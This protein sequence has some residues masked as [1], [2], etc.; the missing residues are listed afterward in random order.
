V[1]PSMRIFRRQ[2]PPEESCVCYS[3]YLLQVET[4]AGR[5]ICS[6][7]QRFIARK[8]FC[9]GFLPRWMPCTVQGH[10]TVA[11]SIQI[12]IDSSMVRTYSFNGHKTEVC[13]LL[14]EIVIY[15]AQVHPGH[16]DLHVA[17]GRLLRG[18]ALQRY[19]GPAVLD[20]GRGHAA[21]G[22]G[23]QHPHQCLREGERRRT[24]RNVLS[25]PRKG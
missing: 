16:A 7:W 1:Q 18:G 19:G 14:A 23:V 15:L 25:P 21:R 5:G 20:G 17:D 4:E 10:P 2:D 13:D 8:S 22:D 9:H 3:K 24:L 6:S 11:A 12:L